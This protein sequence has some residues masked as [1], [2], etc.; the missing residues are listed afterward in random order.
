[1]ARAPRPPRARGGAAPGAADTAIEVVVTVD[2][3]HLGRLADLC[4]ELSAAGL[5]GPQALASAGLVIGNAP[6]SR[7][8]ALRAVGGVTAVEA[9]GTVQLAPPDADV[10]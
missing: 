10:Q 6:A 8:P 4:A 1:M 2:A 3:G 5:Q 7:L 9:S